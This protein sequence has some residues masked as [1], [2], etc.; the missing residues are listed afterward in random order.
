MADTLEPQTDAERQA[1][2]L[3]EK[4]DVRA[5][6]IQQALDIKRGSTHDAVS[7]AAPEVV[8]A[9]TVKEEPLIAI[10]FAELQTLLAPKG[11]D[12]QKQLDDHVAFM[13]RMGVVSDAGQ[14]AANFNTISVRK[15]ELETIP[16]GYKPMLFVDDMAPG[17]SA[18]VFNIP[19]FGQELSNFTKRDP[20][21]PDKIFP[22]QFP[23]GLARLTFTPNVTNLPSSLT[24]KKADTR[25][26]E[27]KQ[28]KHF[29]EPAQWFQFF[30]ECLDKAIRELNLGNGEE[31]KDMDK[32]KRQAIMQ[33]R[34]IDQYLP[35]ATTFTQ[36]PDY[37]N[38]FGSVLGLGWNPGLRGVSV[39]GWGPEDDTHD[40]LG[41]RPSLG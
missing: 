5:D 22:N 18:R 27:M 32:E 35:D 1:V 14:Y 7:A 16:Q 38:Q 21:N 37:R 41:V 20:N 39:G 28:G 29:M 11:I 25:L 10:P 15:S 4:S 40:D 36:F 6:L 3:I 33:D 19:L 8:A 9:E 17:E 2:G 23:S 30:A 13:V 24:D 31:W 34:R 26:D 12:L